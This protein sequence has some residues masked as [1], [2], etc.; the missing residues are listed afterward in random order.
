MVTSVHQ[1]TYYETGFTLFKL[2]LLFTVVQIRQTLFELQVARNLFYMK[3]DSNAVPYVRFDV[4]TALLLKIQVSWDMMLCHSV[5]CSLHSGRFRCHSHLH[6]RRQAAQED[7][8][9][10]LDPEDEGTMT[11]APETTHPGMQCHIP[12]DLNL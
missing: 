3:H 6:H 1:F 2:T 7:M 12:E 11:A 5:S 9:A 4:L 8:L 10:W